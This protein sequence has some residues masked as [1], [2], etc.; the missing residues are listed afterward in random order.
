MSLQLEADDFRQQHRQRLAEHAG[1]GLDAT[2]APAEHGK[3]VHHRGVRVGADERIR[4]GDLERAGLLADRH[5]LLLGPD[6]L[7]E[8]F[9]IDLMADA[10]AGRHHREIRERRLA[11]LQE[12]IA[13][14]VLLV[15][16]DHVLAERLVVAEEVHDHGVV[17]DE[18]D[19]HQRVDFLGIAAE[20][21]HSVAH[22]REIDDRGHA[23][24]VLHQHAGRAES[25]FMLELAL[26]QP[27]ADRDD[28]VL[29]D[30]AAVLVAQQVLQHDLHRIREFRYPLQTILLGGGQAVIHIGFATDL[31]GLAAFEAVERGHV[32]KSQF[33]RDTG[34]GI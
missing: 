28:V 26:L 29:G 4:I 19:R 15:L 6:G 30:A 32:R 34:K 9:E 22:R 14:L 13:L 23:R 33:N 10:G 11:P 8:I 27:L 20:L 21:L 3:A 16:L 2:N 5:L 31:K 25:D 7:G 17:D 12:F 24:E 1:L 18:I